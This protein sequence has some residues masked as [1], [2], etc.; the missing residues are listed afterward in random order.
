[1]LKPIIK[2]GDEFNRLTAIKFNHRNKRSNQYWLF[3]CCCGKEKV[4]C[5]DAV[6]RGITKSC[7]CLKKETTAKTKHGMRKT[8]VYYSWFCMK[9][10]CL[11]P[12][13]PNYKNYGG[14]GITICKEWLE[15][16]NFFRDMG[17]RPQD[18]TLD[19]ID[20]DGNYCKEN[21]KWSA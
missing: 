7:G 13:S 2:K 19:R 9:A 14:R 15:F 10:R 4:I 12:N 6:K 18:R 5:V 1:M 17:E 3:K 16:R 11:N 21:C 20:N 8:R